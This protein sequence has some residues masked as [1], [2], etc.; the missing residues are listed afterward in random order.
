[1]RTVEIKIFKFD[2]LS[3]NAKEHV[4][5]Q[6]SDINVSN[7]IWWGFICDDAK[8]IG[9]DIQEFDLYKKEYKIK[10]IFN[11]SKIKELILKNHGKETETYK[12]VD[13][14]ELRNFKEK[15]DMV[16]ALKKAYI[17]M[18]HNEYEYLTSELA[19]IESINANAYEFHE[20]GKLYSPQS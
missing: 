1:M 9:L 5:Q 20:N 4:L 18:L 15:H 7:M 16:E 6:L 10:P 13:Q 2:E 11:F 17:K 3:D 19:I 12:I 8:D 14:C